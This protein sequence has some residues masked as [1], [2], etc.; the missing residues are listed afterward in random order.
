MI[1]LHVFKFLYHTIIILLPSF[2]NCW[3]SFVANVCFSCL[4]VAIILVE[5]ERKEFRNIQSKIWETINDLNSSDGL[6]LELSSC[7]GFGLLLCDPFCLHWSFIL[8][9][10]L[11]L[12]NSKFWTS[13]YALVT[14]MSTFNGILNSRFMS[15]FLLGILWPHALDH[16]LCK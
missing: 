9:C 16:N 7:I 12:H 2:A 10:I 4:S 5:N 3:S 11:C 8:V 6:I 1:V 13:P 14:W 15:F